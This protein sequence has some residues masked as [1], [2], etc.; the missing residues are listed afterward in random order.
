MFDESATIHSLKKVL[1]V[2]TL[3]YLPIAHAFTI[4][5]GSLL[6]GDTKKPELNSIVYSLTSVTDL[7]NAKII[8]LKNED[9]R[10]EAKNKDWKFDSIEPSITNKCNNSVKIKEYIGKDQIFESAAIFLPE[11]G[12]FWISNNQ[13]ELVY[14]DHWKKKDR[15]QLSGQVNDSLIELCAIS[16]NADGKVSKTCSSSVSSKDVFAMTT[17]AL[18]LSEINTTIA[19]HQLGTR[20]YESSLLDLHDLGFP[21]GKTALDRVKAGHN[22]C[23]GKILRKFKISFA[24]NSKEKSSF[25]VEGALHFCPPG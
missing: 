6:F 8:Y 23:D 24:V 21:E 3:I 2:G 18:R 7:K 11:V 10:R 15:P 12:P 1:A 4:D 9:C 17:Q 16:Q 19:A 20:D 22:L 5:I 25:V 13:K 14:S